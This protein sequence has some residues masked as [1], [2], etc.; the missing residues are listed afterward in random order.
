LV[1]PIRHK[2]ISHLIDKED[3]TS[4]YNEIPVNEV[5]LKVV[6]LSMSSKLEKYL[7]DKTNN[8]DIESPGLSFIITSGCFTCHSVKNKLIG[9]S[10]ER[11]AKRYGNNATSLEALTKKVI[12]GS[13]GVWGSIPMPSH[14]D[15]KTNHAKEI[16]R[17][18]LKNS[19]N[20]DVTYFAGME[21][22]FRTKEKPEKNAAKGVYFLTAS[23][24]DHGLPGMPQLSKRGQQTIILK[25]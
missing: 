8:V 25:N 19:K 14:P 5:I 7:S 3:G 20:P 12:H 11:I 24:A 17:W 15:L 9:P 4:E 13:I 22:T 21:G 23:Y 2:N 18:I 10:F 16:V 1:Y 6:Y